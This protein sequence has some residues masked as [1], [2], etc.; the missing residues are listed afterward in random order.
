MDLE[1]LPLPAA[2]TPPR[3]PSV[4]ILAALV[5]VAGGVVLWVITD[6]LFA[7][8]FAA[9]GPLMLFAS[10]L[11]SIRVG[12]RDRRRATADEEDAW[13][14]ATAVL[15]QRHDDERSALR[16]ASP[17]VAACLK[18][19]PLRSTEPVDHSTRIVLGSGVVSS[20]LRVTGG[21]GERAQLF[22][23]RAASLDDAPITVALGGGICIRGPENIAA[24]VARAIL[25][26]LCL[27]YSPR[28]LS[29][30]GEGIA[31]EGLDGFPHARR[32][33]GGAWT[34]AVDRAGENPTNADG[35][36]LLCGAGDPP[37]EGI[38]TVLDCTEPRRAQVRTATETR[39][40]VVECFS[41]EQ[42]AAVAA[43]APEQQAEGPVLPD[44]VTAS[45]LRVPAAGP[46]LVAAIGRS[47][48]EQVAIDLVADGPHA[49]V[50]GRTGTGKSELLVTWITAMAA[51]HA[52]DD[53]QFVLADF[54]GG[55]AFEALKV[56]PHVVAVVTDLGDAEAR[57]GVESLSAELRRREGILVEH[58]VGD[59]SAAKGALPRLVIVVDEFAALLA[60]QPDLGAVFTDI[61]AR[62]RALGMHLVLGTQ[63][64]SGAI[65]DA[66]AA[67][68]P[69]RMSLR[70]SD[71]V[72]SRA[73][74]GTDDAALIPGGGASRGFAFVRRPQ[75]DAPFAVRV[76]LSG[77]QDITAAA[78]RW[79]SA[80]SPAS[81]WLPALPARLRLAELSRGTG[82]PGVL[83]VG[84]ADEP[85][86]QRQPT[87]TIIAG[88]DR[89]LAV[90]G[91]R[92][93]G[94][95]AAIRLLAVQ[96]R[97]TV[98]IGPDAEQA[99]DALT[100]LIEGRPASLV[101][102]D[103]LDLLL[104]SYPH[105]HAREF[106]DLFERVVRA[107]GGPRRTVVVTA[108]RLTGGAQRV[109]EALPQRA[110]LRLGSRAEHAAAGGD[111]EGFRADR[112][113]GLAWIGS[114]DMQFAWVDERRSVMPRDLA[115]QPMSADGYH[116]RPDHDLCALLV[117]HP[118][119]VAAAVRA[120][121]PTVRVLSVEDA[122]ADLPTGAP[123]VVVGDGAGWQRHWTV[124]QK[125]RASARIVVQAE[126]ATELRAVAGIREVPP[127]ARPHAGRGWL[128]HEAQP[129]RRIHV[130]ALDP[131]RRT[132][133]GASAQITA[134][135]GSSGSP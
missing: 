113:A 43:A 46:G 64:A 118:S 80:I 103:D 110:L 22:R 94:K 34:F 57:R 121:H 68:C 132:A 18:D 52:P 23:R 14:R 48:S 73:V 100:G 55:T 115:Q 97:D 79:E 101:L 49:I 70:V 19:P 78:Q 50:T 12:R 53:V 125:M 135:I 41:R 39:D 5:P 24:A 32:F 25:V 45:E 9:L 71:T 116:W 87:V 58:G 16:R 30:V 7:L 67:N 59:I 72:D 42:A 15:A 123:V 35:R 51:A 92:G 133:Q 134:D 83:V 108:S 114:R 56:L 96:N 111:A 130:P 93:S 109:I 47:A 107:S 75:D 76:A 91:G 89:G 6:S 60:A 131:R 65:K 95:S 112:Q 63:R 62:G 126:C 120:D 40:L 105:D 117:A 69:L 44:E 81:P 84:R 119:S 17:D 85:D 128:L 27:R 61:A 4:P 82:V 29:L 66:L 122:A 98:V 102:C 86:R 90:I 106:L 74:I 104:A 54:K 38:T 11:D 1:P 28:R 31:R 10:L 20:R 77:L 13:T 33:G 99:W 26:Q 127:Y 124:W 36:I 3:R 8:C 37:P 21:E 88:A 2:V 129:L